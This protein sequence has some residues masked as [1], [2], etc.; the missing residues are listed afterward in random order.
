MINLK[1]IRTL[2][3]EK[4]LK[5]QDIAEKVGVTPQG[6]NKMIRT[7]D[8]KLSTLQLIADEL[9]VPLET[10]VS[11]KMPEPIVESQNNSKMEERIR[12]LEE[13]VSLLNEIIRSKDKIIEGLEMRLGE[14]PNKQIVG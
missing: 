11:D 9:Q 4:K 1:V 7:N 6:L 10:F 13:K 2:L 14:S 5:I 8:A 12:N 3:D